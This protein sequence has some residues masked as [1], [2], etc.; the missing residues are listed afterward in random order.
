MPIVE[1]RG[2]SAV[3]APT[4]DA[5]RDGGWGVEL[6]KAPRLTKTR[7]DFSEERTAPRCNKRC[8][9]ASDE[10]KDRKQHN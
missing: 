2:L 10:E 6:G 8:T 7:P 3:C 5:N 4:R 9:L 1:G